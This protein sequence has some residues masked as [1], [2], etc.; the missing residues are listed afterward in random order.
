MKIANKNYQFATNPS[1]DA[2]RSSFNRSFQHKTTFDSGLLIPIFCDEVYPGD[3]FNLNM[4]AFARMATPLFPIMDNL[5]L[6]SFF[7]YVPLR[8]I[9]ENFEKFMGVRR[10]PDDNIDFIMPWITTP[11]I[12]GADEG[13]FADYCGIPTKVPKL[14]YSAMIS[15]A[16]NMIWNEHFRDQNLQEPVVDNFGDGPDPYR[17]Y[18]LLPRG[19]RHDYFTSCLP[20]PQKGD[21]VSLP[22]EGN[23]PII[24]TAPVSGIGMSSV[25]F[26]PSGSVR[27][28]AMVDGVLTTYNESLTSPSPSIFM[29]GTSSSTSASNFSG[30]VIANAD[31]PAS[32]MVA[33]LSNVVAATV[34]DLRQA[35]QYQKILERD[36]RGGTRF[37]ELILSHFGVTIADSTVQRPE[38][39]GGGITNINVHP[40]V[41]TSAAAYGGSEATPQGNLSAFVTTSIMGH[42]FRKSFQEWGVIIGLVNIRADLTYQS[43]LPRMYSRK[44]RFDFYWPELAHLG[45]QPVLNKEIYAQG[46]DVLNSNGDPVDDDAFGYQEIWADLRYKPSQISGAFRS[47]S[48]ASLDVWHLAQDFSSLPLLNNE[49][50]EENIPIERILAVPSEPQFIFDSA[51]QYICARNMPV[52]SIPGLIDHF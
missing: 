27:D 4:T 35:F 33:D 23:A 48:S 43:G 47:N 39:L 17:D 21:A 19:K 41:Q 51:F 1:I 38:Y 20:W 9:W 42:G 2:P 46:A 44:T 36:A 13:D 6:D 29:K 12:A 26:G 7:F 34:N 10:S 15:R 5:Y 11:D 18:V 50:I 31:L 16:Y 40:V 22:L 30:D 25:S 8:I 14:E 32:T 28:S 3:T 52:R 37:P 45:E 49:F 24:G